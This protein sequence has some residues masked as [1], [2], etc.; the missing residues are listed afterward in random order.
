M[1]EIHLERKKGPGAGAWVLGILLVL[2]LLGAGW[3]FA[4]GPGTVP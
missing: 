2:V 1:A 3:Y 4:M